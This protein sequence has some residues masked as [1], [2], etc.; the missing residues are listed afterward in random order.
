MAEAKYNHQTHV[1]GKDESPT[2][3]TNPPVV[4]VRIIGGTKGKGLFAR[5][6]FKEGDVIFEE[7]PLV[8][9]QFLWNSIYG[10][11]ACDFCMR[12]ME[13]AEENAKRLA[14]NPSITL[15]FPQCCA[16]KKETFITCLYC[17]TSYCTP[18]CRDAAWSQHHETLCRGSYTLD[19]NHPVV[20]LQEAWRN[21][22]YPPETANIMLVA[23][24]IATV[25]QAKHKQGA[26]CLFD[27]FCHN[28]VNEEEEIAHKLLGAQFQVQIINFYEQLE[29]L[30]QLMMNVVYEENV[31]QWYTPAGFQSLIALVGMN[32][33]GI[34]TTPLGIWVKNCDNLDLPEDERNNLDNFIDKL[35][36]DIENGNKLKLNSKKSGGFLNNEGSALYP[37]QSSC[38]LPSN[39]SCVPNAEA[40]FLDNNFNLV[41]IATSDI[42]IDEE[43]C[44]SYLDECNKDRS[45]HSRRKIL[46][47]NYLFNCKCEKCQAQIN[48]ED[49]T[50]IDEDDDEDD[51]ENGDI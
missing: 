30:R 41:M 45:R 10:Y 16:T 43:I 38:K 46:R 8:C 18:E 37:L 26:I 2:T 27:Q 32:G 9:C 21:M 28:T 22:H 7:R 36:T 44:V 40:T 24:I 35:Y 33:Q 17:D 20:Q 12:P 19:S 42:D 1:V 6:K 31:Q 34:G 48:D 23:R 15:P 51:K 5:K 13:S 4:E 49:A 50:S 14:A 39:H 47:E 25:K 3:S 29:T 11:L